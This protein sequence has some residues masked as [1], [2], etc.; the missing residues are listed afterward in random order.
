MVTRGKVVRDHLEAVLIVDGEVA[1]WS[2]GSLK[3]AAGGFLAMNSC[4]LRVVVGRVR[5]GVVLSFGCCHC[6]DAKV[7]I[8]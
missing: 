7:R 3:I 6:R 1:Y 5:I 2:V 4:G 8:D